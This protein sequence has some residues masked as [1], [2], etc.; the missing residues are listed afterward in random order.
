MNAYRIPLAASLGSSVFLLLGAMAGCGSDEP[1][2]LPGA[3]GEDGGGSSGNGGNGIGNGGG[4]TNGA[5]GNGGGGLSSRLGARC[6]DDSECGG[7]DLFCLTSDSNEFLDGGPPNGMCAAR[8]TDAAPEDC[9]NIE[10]NSICVLT[11]DTDG[12]CMP[13][14]QLGVSSPGKCQGRPDFACSPRSMAQN[15]AVGYCRPTCGNDLD[16]GDRVCDLG[17]GIC[18][19]SLSGSG[20]PIGAKCATD[21]DCATGFCIAYGPDPDAPSACTAGCVLGT[22]ASSCGSDPSSSD[23]APAACLF[24]TDANS[25]TGDVGLCGQLCSCNGDCLHPDMVC[26][27]VQGLAAETNGQAGVCDTAMQPDGTVSE[28]IPCEGGRDG[29]M[30]E[31]EAGP[32]DAGPGPGADASP[33]AA[34]P[35]P[36]ATAPPDAG[37]AD[38]AGD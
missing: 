33:D 31:S 18:V 36:D 14:C 23:P 24:Q 34:E 27:P 19:D 11:T 17:S 38:A 26:N 5:G 21:D 4:A 20:A 25:T 28:G 30:P 1:G 12:L 22:F 37:P 15:S 9:Q 16:C 32:P 8:C 35:V 7:G 13:L 2:V 3:V 6:L 10:P 29:G